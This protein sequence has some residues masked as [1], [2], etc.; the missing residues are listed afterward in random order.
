MPR[1]YV[2][3][4]L[5]LWSILLIPQSNAK[6][7]RQAKEAYHQRDWVNA[8]RL[9]EKLLLRD[10][11]RLEWYYPYAEALF[12]NYDLDEALS[13]FTLVT[14]HDT[15]KKYPLA[16]FYKAQI[17]QAK[18]NYKEAAKNYKKFLGIKKKNI[19]EFHKKFAE[20][21]LIGCES[22]LM[23]RPSKNDLVLFAL[24]TFV[25]STLSE[26]AP[27]ELDSVLYFSSLRNKIRR[28][29]DDH[30]KN[31][32]YIRNFKSDKK[33]ILALDTTLNSEFSDNGN[34]FPVPGTNWVLFSRCR[35]VTPYEYRCEIWKTRKNGN[36]YSMP[37]KLPVQVNFPGANTTHPHM[38][39]MN[40]KWYLFFSSDRPGTTGKLDLWK[41]EVISLD[42]NQFGIPENLGPKINT[43]DDDISPWFDGDEK[44]L[45]FS[46]RFHPGFGGF[47]IFYSL[48]SSDTFSKPVNA[49]VPINSSHNDVYYTV[50]NSRTF[51]Y[52]SSNRKGSRFEGKQNCC[53]DIYRFPILS[54]KKDSLPTPKTDSA[55][56]FKDQLKLLV[57]LTL[58]FHNDE[59]DPKTRNTQTSKSYDETYF[60][61]LKL[62]DEY[63]K[64]Y[65]SGLDKNE[66]EIAEGRIEDF[67]ADSVKAGYDDLMKFSSMMEKILSRG[68]DTVYVT[69]KGY[70]SPLAST[71]Y[72]INLAKRRISSLKNFFAKYKDGLFKPYLDGTA[73]NGSRI[74]YEDVDIGELPFSKVSD[75]L[76]DKKNSVYSPY[77]ARERKIQILAVKFSDKNNTDGKLSD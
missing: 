26:Y 69:I 59:P 74:I 1:L 6:L 11:S 15:K 58:Y 36:R 68:R 4:I 8:A 23:T 64:E 20:Q 50:N 51:A 46:S 76:R 31:K 47:D 13:R 42:Q 28:F 63:K 72:N 17:L 32:I 25:N 45:F 35:N 52:L 48:L 7:Y 37:E 73:P 5:F 29:E 10:S 30:H 61:Y 24:D 62:T 54:V 71:D 44:K 55:L 43:P 27:L 2:T 38:A 39:K 12:F 9:F 19:S 65:A 40:D 33:E 22:A 66:R 16:H 41:C 77:A 75:D 14:L 57:P 34:Y 21:Q 60:A 53:N 56:V 18:E 67:F 3:F 49:G 70:C